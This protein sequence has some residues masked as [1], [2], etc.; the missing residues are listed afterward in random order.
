[1]TDHA[2]ELRHELVD[3]QQ[4]LRGLGLLDGAKRQPGGGY[5]VRCP[6]PGHQEKTPSC[7]V[8][9]K[10]GVVF[11]HCFACHEAGD[12][13][14]LVAVVRGLDVTRDFQRVL[15]EAAHLASRWDI[16]ESIE[17]RER[18]EQR[19]R[20]APP[21]AKP[22]A[23][24]PAQED[25]HHLDDAVFCR[26]ANILGRLCP[27]TSQDDVVGYL[28][29][30]AAPLVAMAE[31]HGWMA[32]PPPK[33]QR[34]V[35]DAIVK[36]VGLDAWKACGLAHREDLTRI[37]WPNHR[38][39]MPWRAPWCR[40]WRGPQ[41][42]V[43]TLQRRLVAPAGPEI[44]KAVFP[45]SRRTAWPYGAEAVQQ[46]P[47]LPVYLVEGALDTLSLAWL[48]AQQ[49]DPGV[50]LGLP[51]VAAWDARWAPLLAGR[52]VVVAVD[53]DV[54]GERAVQRVAERCYGGG[55]T[56][57]RR[58]RLLNTKDWTEGLERMTQ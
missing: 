31:A 52:T 30:R 39:V 36:A 38:L 56:H 1:M 27:L 18:A 41:G 48:L 12:V 47:G 6:C 33:A 2:A 57:V 35:V 44:P 8:Q 50:V 22:P 55:A 53:A 32:L 5:F 45:R 43:Q 49:H 29:G 28:A 16:I 17:G 10:D 11:Y 21:K 51:G 13:L 58:R 26:I 42:Y 7:S 40:P 15:V 24:P 9:R 14:S 46:W 4:V 37:S 20:T 25:D 23:Q 19:R 34:H 3:V 54:A